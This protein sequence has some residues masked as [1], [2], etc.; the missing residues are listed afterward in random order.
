MAPRFRPLKGHPYH[1]KSTLELRYLIED[2]GQ[3]AVYMRD[4]SPEAEA[5]YLDQVNDACTILHYR[6]KNA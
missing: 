6:E 5:K 1:E 2:A 4:H 3:A